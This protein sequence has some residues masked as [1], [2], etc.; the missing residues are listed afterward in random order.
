MKKRLTLLLSM[1]L[2]IGLLAACGNNANQG[3]NGTNS[4]GT[5]NGKKD[6][7]IAL[8]LPE[9]IGVNPF[10]ELMDKGF[11]KA[12]ED[13]GVTIKTMESSDANA[14]EQNFR[15]AVADGY[16]MIITATY[17]AEDALRKIAAE[18]P[19]LPIA[20]IDHVI[21]DVPNVRSA[22]FIENQASFLLGAAAGLVTESNVVGN[23]VAVEGAQMDKYTI[24]FAKGLAYTN[25]EAK[26]LTSYVGSYVDSAKS[27][28]LALQQNAQG[29]DFIAGLAA[30]GDFG[31]FEAAKEKGFYASGQDVDRTVIDPEHVILSQLK[32]VDTVTY[33]TVKL[34]VEDKFDFGTTF[35]GL[36]EGGVGLT[37]VTTESESPRSD[38][39][40]DEDIAQLKEIAEGIKDGS[41]DTSITK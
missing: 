2:V 31:I 5:G 41:I 18:N 19:N 17:Q 38:K 32:E 23:V 9:Q 16:D 8:V 27:K 24:G 1:V 29:A 13:F 7:K 36:A 26:V 15:A 21:E 12:G 20:I 39:L 35:Y 6:I 33:D 30:V 3:S 10:F 37:F 25:P 28:E 22:A 11:K 40:T 4:E 14:F 34:F